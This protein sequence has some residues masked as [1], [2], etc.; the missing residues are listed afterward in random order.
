NSD[1]PTNNNSFWRYVGNT[2]NENRLT[3]G[4]WRWLLYDLDRAFRRPETN[5]LEQTFQLD[6]DKDPVKASELYKRLISHPEVRQRFITRFADLINTSLT[7]ERMDLFIDRTRQALEPEMP[8]H[9]ARWGA[10][11]SMGYW[12]NRLDNMSDFAH[13]RPDLQR[14]HLQEFFD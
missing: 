1:W 13:K 4:K 2:V 11:I 10:P 12:E 3:D 7:P 5:M 8:R 14:Q 9:I 6:E